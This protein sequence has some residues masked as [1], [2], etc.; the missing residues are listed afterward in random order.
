MCKWVINIQSHRVTSCLFV[1][2]TD[3]KRGHYELCKKICNKKK[4]TTNVNG[5]ISEDY[6]R[7]NI[8]VFETRKCVAM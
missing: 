6:T 7:Y 8:L 2:I 5:M 3:N 4:F 1:F